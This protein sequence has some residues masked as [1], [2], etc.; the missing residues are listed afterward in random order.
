MLKLFGLSLVNKY[1]NI[2]YIK[3]RQVLTVLV[4]GRLKQ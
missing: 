2:Y 3:G 4:S 1:F